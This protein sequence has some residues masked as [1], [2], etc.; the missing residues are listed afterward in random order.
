MV[1]TLALLLLLLFRSPSSGNLASVTFTF[2]SSF[3]IPGRSAV[4]TSLPYACFTSMAG[5]HTA[6][7]GFL[8][9]KAVH[10]VSELPHQANGFIP[11]R[12]PRNREDSKP[13]CG[14]VRPFRLVVSLQLHLSLFF[15]PI[16]D[17]HRFP[18][19]PAPYF[20]CLYV[21]DRMHRQL[22]SSKAAGCRLIAHQR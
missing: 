14:W 17:L 18:H 21:G 22:P 15:P 4:T 10:T 1:V 16:T 9:K 19:S 12:P 20:A 7:L 3:F 13:G 2:T 11:K 6:T 8:N 5:L